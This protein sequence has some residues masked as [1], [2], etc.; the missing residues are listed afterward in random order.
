MT[1]T[2]QSP[3]AAPGPRLLPFHEV[4]AQVSLCRTSIYE[5]IGRGAFPKP[6]KIGRA[7]RWLSTEIDAW[8]VSVATAQASA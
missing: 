7:S 8:V 2:S 1:D 4:R 6:A 5:M 3:S